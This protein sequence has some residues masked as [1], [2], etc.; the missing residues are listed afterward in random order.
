MLAMT[1]AFSIVALIAFLIVLS[2]THYNTK[3]VMDPPSIRGFKRDQLTTTIVLIFKRSRWINVNLASVKAQRGVDARFE[4]ERSGVVKVTLSSRY[5]G[6]YSSLTLQFEIVDV[7]NLFK[8]QIQVVSVDFLYE[9]LPLSI[10]RQ[11]P[12]SRP[13][14]LT[15]GEKSGK[16]PGSSLELYSLEEYTPFTETK[17]VMWKR[18]AR[19]PDEKLIVRVRDSSIPRLVSI[20]FV[21]IKKRQDQDYLEWM[22]LV[23]EAIGTMGNSLL[24]A[25][26]LVEILQTS[27]EDPGSVLVH[28]ITDLDG[29]SNAVMQ[30]SV[31]PDPGKE[32]E[33]VFRVIDRS[34]ILVC[35][36]RELE[37]HL[38]APP[39]S[40]KP[41]LAVMEKRASPYVVGQQTMIYTG[42]EDVRKLISNVL[43]M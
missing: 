23:C 1:L 40:K 31:P 32:M 8:K 43:E 15:L 38:V 3:M 36:M 39:I 7:L 34:D 42:V 35:G 9:S 19:M 37:D 25:G 26:C 20:G 30:L 17:N 41:A 24:T 22:D 5:A 21:Q 18:V 29:L 4:V 33:N 6:R 16:S 12:H 11:I 14:P 13:M 2:V 27:I 10:L 28:E